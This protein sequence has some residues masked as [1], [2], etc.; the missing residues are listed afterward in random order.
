MPKFVVAEQNSGV[1]EQTKK[2]T[3]GGK[4]LFSYLALWRRDS[5]DV[6]ARELARRVGVGGTGASSLSE[7][8]TSS[9]G[10]AASVLRQWMYPRSEVELGGSW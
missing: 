7:I 10:K 8:S 5:V 2:R 3:R 9:S 1:V 6:G 4:R